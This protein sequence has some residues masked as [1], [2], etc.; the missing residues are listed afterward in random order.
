[1]Q[2]NGVRMYKYCKGADVTRKSAFAYGDVIEVFLHVPRTLGESGVVLRGNRDGCGDYDVPMTVYTQNETDTVYSVELDTKALCCPEQLSGLFYY[3]FLFLKGFDTMFTE[4]INNVDFYL[5]RSSGARFRLL[6]FE[7]TYHTPS[8]FGKGVMY[9]IFVDRFCRGQGPV[10]T[11]DD[12]E[13]DPDWEN[14]VPQYAPYPGAPVSNNVF[15]GGNLWGVAE[16]LDYLESLGVKVIYLSPIFKAYSNHK[17]DTGD[18]EHVDP[19]FGGDDA[20]KHLLA[21]ARKKGMRVVLDGVFNHTGDDSRYFNRYGKYK[22]LGAYQSPTSPYADWYSFR[23]YPDEYDSWWGI[24]ILPRLN[25]TTESCRKY[26][27][28]EQGIARKYVKMGIGGWRLDVADELSNEFLDEFRAAVK[29]ESDGECVVIGEVWE[30]AADKI[31]YSKRRRYLSGK[32]LDSVMNYPVRNGILDFIRYRDAEGL[33]HVLT[34]LYSSYPEEVCHA[35]MNLVG[36]HD[37][38]RIMTMLGSSE[39]DLDKSNDGLAAY[40]L[41]AEKRAEA[42]NLVKIAAALQYTVFGIPSLYYGDELGLEGARDPFCRMPMPWHDVDDPVRAELLAYYQKLG[43]MRTT[44]PALDGGSFEFLY[45]DES[46][47]AFARRAEGREI[48][49]AASRHEQ[50]VTL[51][52]KGEFE[53]LLCGTRGSGA[54]RIEPDSVLILERIGGQSI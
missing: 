48:V 47:I 50:T 11:R 3:E 42:M 28:G 18:Y 22:E 43:E 15:F 21:Q 53:D 23:S 46:C 17:Y 37:T 10:G 14:G 27:T 30:N 20:F 51:P 8:W 1:M 7:N 13:I 5:S 34:E 49:V 16:K 26:F 32:Q 25:H 36:T 39:E 6:I 9:H 54:L 29:D 45:H 41:S 38:E 24:P 31:A 52:I 12:A 2:S 4:S 40:R 44:H 19:M 33:Y 35:L